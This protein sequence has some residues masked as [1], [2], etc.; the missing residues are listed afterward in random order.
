MSKFFSIY[1]NT[2]WDKLPDENLTIV[3]LL[4]LKTIFQNYPV[5]EPSFFDDLTSNISNQQH[6]S[7]YKSIKRVVGPDREDYEIKN[8]NFIWAMDNKNRIFQ[9][10]FQKVTSGKDSKRILAAL[11]PPELGKLFVQYKA[12]AILRTLSLL[13]K[14]EQI[15]FLI[16]L[17]PK[18]KSIAEEQ[19]II[20][21]NKQDL[22]EL[23]LINML[24]KIPN[25]QGQWFPNF[26]PRCPNCNE[27]M[28]ELKGYTVGFG[29]LI[30][31]RCGYKN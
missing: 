16:I 22:D 20:K 21:F 30:C 23:Q 29:K 1:I 9:F 19:Q 25:L 28:I 26:A 24:K 6:Y 10:L 11:A 12:D 8:W 17:T 27:L 2:P 5:I 7:W 14:P 4:S 13:N 15:K 31:P 18:G 3:K